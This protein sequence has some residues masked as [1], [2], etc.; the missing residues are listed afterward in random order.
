MF[1]TV[2]MLTSTTVQNAR[3]RRSRRKR[4]VRR[5]GP[6]E[7]ARLSRMP[8]T[9]GL[10]TSECVM[11]CLETLFSERPRFSCTSADSE[12]TSFSTENSV[13]ESISEKIGSGRDPGLPTYTRSV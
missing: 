12:L 11:L 6:I 5:T 10:M 4:A 3:E 7:I 9:A 2:Q 1:K 8:S 13:A